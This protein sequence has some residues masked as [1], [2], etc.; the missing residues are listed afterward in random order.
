[1]FLRKLLDDMQPTMLWTDET[2]FTVP[3]INN[4][5]NYR[6]RTKNNESVHVELRTSSRRQKPSLFMVWI[7]VTT[8]GLKTPLAFVE[9]GVNI[10]QHVCLNMLKDKV[11][12]WKNAL[13]LNN[14]LT[15]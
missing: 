6:V 3:A 7:R 15:L 11:V 12:A 8:N 10:N 1:M 2:F 9:D 4:S 13:I 5:K 14:G